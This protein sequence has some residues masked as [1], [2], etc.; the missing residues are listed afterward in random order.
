MRCAREHLTHHPALHTREREGSIV[1]GVF[2]VRSDCVGVCVCVCV[3]E[4]ERERDREREIE[5]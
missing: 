4:I 5:R 2:G 3:R 1:A